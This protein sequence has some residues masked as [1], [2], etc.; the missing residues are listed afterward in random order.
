MVFHVVDPC[1][2]QKIFV[3]SLKVDFGTKRRYLLVLGRKFAFTDSCPHVSGCQM[4][5]FPPSCRHRD[6]YDVHHHHHNARRY[7]M[8]FTASQQRLCGPAN[9][10]AWSSH[11][12]SPF[13]GAHFSMLGPARNQQ[14]STSQSCAARSNL[15]GWS[16]DNALPK[17]LHEGIHRSR[18]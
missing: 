6:N 1:G 15:T 4:A 11:T 9:T 5:T 13:C 17:L 16:Q 2:A 3:F 8:Y 14:D 18:G 12:V 7:I 10:I